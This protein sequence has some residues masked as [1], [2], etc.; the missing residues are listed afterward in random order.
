VHF[1]QLDAGKLQAALLG[2]HEPDTLLST[3]I[4]RLTSSQP[5]VW[6]RIDGTAR[7]DSLV[8]GPVELKDAVATLHILP[9][10]A[11]F[12][13]FDAGLLDGTIHATGKLANGA[14]PSYSMQGTFS[15]LSAP[16]VCQ[17]LAL[18]CNGGALDGNGTVDLAGFTDKDLGASAK[19][20]LHFEWRH[21]AFAKDPAIPIPAA[22]AR[23][24]HWTADAVIANG[25]ITLQ[26][27]QAQ[28]GAHKTA[29]K[30]AITFG[31]PPKVSFA[32]SKSVQTAKR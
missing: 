17:L 13:S 8:L 1:D 16:A 10:G 28:Q 6:P 24:D 12:K 3:L 2:A 21:G 26:Q 14:K 9:T 25:A 20:T 19:G 4:A 30:A 23:F 11:E 22:L 7:V 5:P 15:K 18:R 32:A 27:N 29:I 31:D